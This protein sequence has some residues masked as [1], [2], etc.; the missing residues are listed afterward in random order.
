MLSHPCRLPSPGMSTM[1]KGQSLPSKSLLSADEEPQGQ[2]KASEKVSI[3]ESLKS[4]TKH[5]YVYLPSRTRTRVLLA[6]EVGLQTHP[7]KNPNWIWKDWH[8]P[9]RPPTPTHLPVFLFPGFCSPCV[10]PL[11]HPICVSLR[12]PGGGHPGTRL[13]CRGSQI[14][15]RCHFSDFARECLVAV[16]AYLMAKNVFCP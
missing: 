8:S 5:V 1:S 2:I 9:P 13:A 16:K 14:W 7:R 4:K 10:F 15:K 6:Q 3:E 11:P 12:I